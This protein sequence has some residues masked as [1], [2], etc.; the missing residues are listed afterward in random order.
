[1][2]N[3]CELYE[4]VM[5]PSLPKLDA[6]CLLG[7]AHR[8]SLTHGVTQRLS[9]TTHA[10]PSRT[11]GGLRTAPRRGSGHRFVLPGLQCAPHAGVRQGAT[12]IGPCFPTKSSGSHPS[13][14]TRK[15]SQVLAPPSWSLSALDKTRDW[16][17]LLLPH[18]AL[19]GEE[20]RRATSLGLLL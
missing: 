3:G 8:K 12:G 14:Q 6:C 19:G 13:L 15:R 9:D 16:T 18:I 4:N 10:Q 7:P 2:T 5:A 11:Q 17:E 20:D 1:M